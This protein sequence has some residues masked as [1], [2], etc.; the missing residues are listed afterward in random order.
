M[1]RFRLPKFLSFKSNALPHWGMM[2]GLLSLFALA[3]LAVAMLVAVF[4]YKFAY[5]QG[6]VDAI[7]ESEITTD[8]ELLTSQSLQ[9]I[10]LQNNRLRTE[11]D[12]AKQ[13]RDISLT[14]L[15]QLRQDMETLQITN[16]QLQQSVDIF[17][18]KIAD[19]GGI[20]LQVIG[21]EI[22]PL[23]ENA[24]EYRFDVLMVNKDGKPT[25]LTAKLDLLNDTSFV[26]VPLN[27]S[28]YQINGI[29]RIRGRFIMPDNFKPMQVKLTL[30]AGGQQVKQLYNWR[31]GK[32]KDN[33]PLSLAELPKTNE[34]PIKT[35]LNNK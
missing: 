3:M 22:E 30:S 9:D 34:R 20:D 14:N 17:S 21:A 28:Q 7:K 29:S 5:K 23:P 16:E 31:L 4:A 8:G 19:S 12:N 32:R 15:S 25:T 24:F 6:R 10:R 13:E 27:P 33:L 26:N 18:Q 2:T 1:I 11:A 35:F